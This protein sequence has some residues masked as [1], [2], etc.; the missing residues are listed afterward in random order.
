MFRADSLPANRQKNHLWRSTLKEGPPSIETET[1]R[2][3]NPQ[4]RTTNNGNLI[5]FGTGHHNL[6]IGAIM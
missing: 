4:E 3:G 6:F 1:I 2:G 5:T